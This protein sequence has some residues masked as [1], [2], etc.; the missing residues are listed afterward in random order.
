ML[1]KQD[2]SHVFIAWMPG[3]MRFEIGTVLLTLLLNI[4]AT[5]KLETRS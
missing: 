3:N 1:L 5:R 4:V 2:L